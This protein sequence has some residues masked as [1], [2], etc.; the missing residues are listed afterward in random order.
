MNLEELKGIT[1]HFSTN[2]NIDRRC[3]AAAGE[4]KDHVPSVAP[5]STFETKILE[6]QNVDVAELISSFESKKDKLGQ[7]QNDFE[8]L[9]DTFGSQVEQA[10]LRIAQPGCL[11]NNRPQFSPTPE[12]LSSLSSLDKFGPERADRSNSGKNKSVLVAGDTNIL[13]AQTFSKG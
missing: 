8:T 5:T 9:I 4:I 7:L 11:V 6:I 1:A 3:S 12:P 10:K 2:S 13:L